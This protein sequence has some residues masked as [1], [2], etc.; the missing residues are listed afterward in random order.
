[1]KLLLLLFICYIL[2]IYTYYK[3]NIEGE[4]KKKKISFSQ[5]KKIL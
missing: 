2:V 5:N 3:M 4:E 1:M